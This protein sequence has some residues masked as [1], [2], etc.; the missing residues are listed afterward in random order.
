ML[1]YFVIYIRYIIQQTGV[2]NTK[3]LQIQDPDTLHMSLTIS[4]VWNKC[5]LI[6]WGEYLSWV[7]IHDQVP[8][9]EPH[10]RNHQHV[11]KHIRSGRWMQCYYN[12][13]RIKR[14]VS[15]A[16]SELP[17]WTWIFNQIVMHIMLLYLYFEILWHFR[18]FIS[19]NQLKIECL[20]GKQQQE[21]F[22]LILL[23]DR[24][25]YHNIDLDLWHH[26]SIK[27]MGSFI[28]KPV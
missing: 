28:N 4:S 17:R 10:R 2:I 14:K 25:C 5:S 26:A 24:N 11:S 15:M 3:A 6:T 13:Y 9:I 21:R 22:L 12:T 18:F 8:D 16:E 20:L 27:E 19:G 7:H 23:L 1:C